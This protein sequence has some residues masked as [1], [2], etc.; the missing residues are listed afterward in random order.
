MAIN[1]NVLQHSD[2]VKEIVDYLQRQPSINRTM[3]VAVVEGDIE[4][5]LKYKP[6]MEK[7]IESYLNGLMEN[8][9]KFGSIRVLTLDDLLKSLSSNGNA[10]IP[11]ITYDRD[12]KEMNLQG[13]A[14]IK[15]YTLKGFLTA[16][17]YSDI[18]FLRGKVSGGKKVVFIE[19]HPV[20]FSISNINTKIK[21]SREGDK[22][23][24]NIYST[25]EGEVKEYYAGKEVFNNS[26]IK[27]LEE[28]FNESLSKEFQDII[29][30][31]QKE[32]G[33]D[34]I[35]LRENVEKYHPFIWR[36][37]GNNWDAVYKNSEVNVFV[38]TKIRRVGVVK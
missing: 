37:L 6:K 31:T 33:I 11:Y 21:T 35:G 29:K 20:D 34:V 19:G 30:I 7:N 12:K 17:E 15:D 28:N 26:F 36:Q 4:Q 3:L 1:K 14:M 2:T 32:N 23:I 22:L 16:R 8:N 5:F 38:T 13:V 10:I 25:I 9:A 27:D 18:E 24:F